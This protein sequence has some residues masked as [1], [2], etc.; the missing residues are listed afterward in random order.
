MR[1]TSGKGARER[2]PLTPDIL[3]RLKGVWVKS[4]HDPVIWAV[5][6]LCFFAFLR[7]GEMTTPDTKTYDPAVH[8]FYSDIALDNARNQTFLSVHQAIQN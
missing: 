7:V 4:A 8:L 1:A 5:C 2:L 3:R 6:C